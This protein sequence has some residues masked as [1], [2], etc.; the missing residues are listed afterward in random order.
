MLISKIHFEFCH[1]NEYI[2]VEILKIKRYMQVLNQNGHYELVRPVVL[3]K[4]SAGLNELGLAFLGYKHH[5][6]CVENLKIHLSF[7]G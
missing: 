5:I 3:F 1:T 6:N 4:M 7:T 2:E